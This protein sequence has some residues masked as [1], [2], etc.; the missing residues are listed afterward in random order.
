MPHY[1]E[2]GKSVILYCNYSIPLKQLY[3]IEWQKNEKKIYQYVKVRKQ[4]MKNFTIP[5]GTFDVSDSCFLR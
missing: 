1:V 4:P 2:K 5:G 3:K